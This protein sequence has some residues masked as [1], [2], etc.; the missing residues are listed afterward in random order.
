MAAES[1]AIELLATALTL[2]D[3][4]EGAA[5]AGGAE[6]LA[7]AV[8]TMARSMASC[9][10]ALLPPAWGTAAVCDGWTAPMA[11]LAVATIELAE[12]VVV[13]TA[14]G[15]ATG[16]VVTVAGA[17]AVPWYTAMTSPSVMHMSV[18][19]S[20]LSSCA[21]TI[22]SITFRAPRAFSGGLRS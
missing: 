3:V 10:S 8:A 20:I 16:V 12:I 17:T 19:S 9:S 5:A 4:V 11:V 14:A 6:T 15:A 1:T 18:Q 22:A 13:G 21:S 7:E 2:T